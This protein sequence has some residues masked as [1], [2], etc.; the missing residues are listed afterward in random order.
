MEQALSVLD[1]LKQKFP[2]SDLAE[3][4]LSRKAEILVTLQK[5]SGAAKVYRDLLAKYPEG[6]DCEEA[7]FRLGQLYQEKLNLPDKAE[8]IYK[9][10]VLNH[11][12]SIYIEEA[13]KR[14][15]ALR[16]K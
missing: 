11:P 14:F 2:Y 6:R 1:S 13:R 12:G 5:Y 15:R 9:D 3:E 7:R 4:V 10:I 8:A 16:E